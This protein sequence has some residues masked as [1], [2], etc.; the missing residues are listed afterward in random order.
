MLADVSDQETLKSV[1]GGL[2]VYFVSV[3]ALYF[4]FAGLVGR[5]CFYYR[6]LESVCHK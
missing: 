2:F 5:R 6:C 3:R 1:W 4:Y